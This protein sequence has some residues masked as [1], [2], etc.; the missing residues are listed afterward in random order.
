MFCIFTLIAIANWRVRDFSTK[1]G[2]TI[3]LY[4]IL[5]LIFKYFL[6]NKYKSSLLVKRTL[7]INN[8]LNNNLVS[9]MKW[10]G[11]GLY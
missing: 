3:H 2:Q 5:I 11:V 9:G 8:S 7:K 10:G 6:Y 1:F 4:K